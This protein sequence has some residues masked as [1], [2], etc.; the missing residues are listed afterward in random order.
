LGQ[1]FNSKLGCI[2]ICAVSAS[3]NMQPL[4]KIKT[5]PRVRPGS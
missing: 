5:R 3:H 4:L 2:A 1:V